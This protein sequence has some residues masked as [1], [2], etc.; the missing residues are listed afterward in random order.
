VFE[1]QSFLW[2]V[3]KHPELSALFAQ[4]PGA[5]LDSYRVE[6][7]ARAALVRLD[8]KALY[9]MGANPYLLY[10]CALQLGVPRETYY[11]DLRRESA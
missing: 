1:L 10:F 4:D 6:G 2:A 9:E 5:A 3:R 11:A 8:F 7:P